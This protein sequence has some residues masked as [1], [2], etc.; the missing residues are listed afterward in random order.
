V[1]TVQGLIRRRILVNYRVDPEIIGRLLPAPFRPKLLGDSGMA[2]ICL[3]R[4]EQIRPQS[5]RLAVGLSSE[6]AA[7]RI[8]VS[9][10][11]EAGETSEGVYI[12]R[13]DSSSR[14]N[15]WAGGRLFP[16]EH[17]AATFR[18]RESAET[19]SLAMRSRDGEIAVEIEAHSAASLPKS[20]GFKTLEE[21]SSFFERGSLGYSA[22]SKSSRL[23]SLYLCAQTW[24]VE[25][26]EI[27][28]LSTSYFSD[29][30]L[31][32]KGTAEFDS[33]LLMRD[34]PHQWRAGP[35]IAAASE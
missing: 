32:P 31:F 14:W 3:I 27:D 15:R 20:S 21:A 34:I 12:P 33:A 18:V 25:P 26:L 30:R 23:D 17:H 2:G 7:H 6:N 28:F 10:R 19:L 24:K 13:R 9:W 35:P 11:N 5:L 29:E 22:R 16:G 1:L 8:A 4:L